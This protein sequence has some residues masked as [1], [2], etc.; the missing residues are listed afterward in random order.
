M[1]SL[2]PLVLLVVA[3]C[4]DTIY[5]KP[6]TAE[7]TTPTD[8]TNPTDSGPT[9]TTDSNT[10]TT[11]SSDDF[12]AVVSIFNQSC[13]GCHDAATPDSDLDLQ[14]DPHAALVGVTS[15]TYGVI[16][17]V[18]GSAATSLLY[19]K[20]ANLQS[21]SQGGVM[22]TTGSL[23]ADKLAIIETWI[24]SGA[25]A[26]CD[27]TID[28]STTGGH[29]PPG[30]DDPDVHGIDA[31]CQAEACTE[32]HGTDL[33]GGTSGVSCDDCHAATDPGWKTDCT[34]CHGGTETPGGAPPVDIDGS[35]TGLSFPEHTSHVTEGNHAA[36][37]CEQCHT[38][39]SS[40]L[41]VG[42]FI[43]G[44]TTECA[45]EVVFTAGLSSRG[46]YAG[47]GSCNNL[48]C[49]SNGQSTTSTGSARTGASYRCDS[50]H[51]DDSGLS[52]RHGDHIGEDGISC[53]DCHAATASGSTTIIGPDQHVD[54]EK[55]V[56]FA[57]SGMTRTSGRCTGSC[58]GES[59]SNR[60]WTE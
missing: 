8:I 52:G 33:D 56:V 15:P 48:Y 27:G 23:S 28:T 58:H 47:G 34:W 26:E 10:G 54:G 17:V 9:G 18:P 7:V 20:M 38:T 45:A 49:H 43:I 60:S 2:L 35:S 41:S 5:G 16:R 12:C 1:R 55:D 39:P 53:D 14:T 37:G 4:D 46:T 24:D 6:D 50:C 30:Y 42:H 44:D 29:H 31:K 11:P 25:S 32:C 3:G 13:V 21:G 19:L 57:S 36:W 51:D 22:P 59:H 40:A